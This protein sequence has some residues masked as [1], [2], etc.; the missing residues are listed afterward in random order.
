MNSE[1]VTKT[2][3]SLRRAELFEDREGVRLFGTTATEQAI[4]TLNGDDVQDVANLSANA[5]FSYEY[6]PGPNRPM[7][8]GAPNANSAKDE[9]T[10]L[11]MPHDEILQ[12]AVPLTPKSHMHWALW[13]V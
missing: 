6:I 3:S 9:R 10:I 7:L 4:M 5:G 11:Q 13:N 1:P 12:S 2:G 8:C